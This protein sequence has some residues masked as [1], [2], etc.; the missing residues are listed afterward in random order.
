MRSRTTVALV[1]LRA[2]AGGDFFADTPFCLAAGELRALGHRADVFEVYLD[3][4]DAETSALR[5]DAVVAAIDDGGYGLVVFEHVWQP[6]L[7]R[8]ISALGAVVLLT[9]PDAAIVAPPLL[10]LRHLT[11]N[12]QP[13]LDLVAALADGSDLLQLRNLTVESERGEV[14][15]SLLEQ[16]HPQVADALRPFCPI[17]DVR[18]I[19]VEQARDGSIPPQ[20]KSLD[21]NKGCPFSAPVRE[22]PRFT[23]LALPDAGVTLAGC[24]FCF[25]GGDYQALTWRETVRIHCEQIAYY[26]RELAGHT[27]RGLDE[28]VLRD[29]HAIRYLPHLLREAI[30][31]G[32]PPLGILVPGRGDAILRYG[33]ALREAA[34]IA[35][36]TGFWFTIYLIGFE[37][38]SDDQLELYNKGVRAEDYAQALVGLRDLHHTHPETFRLYAYGSSS[39]I[40]WNPWTT[41]DDVLLTT[42]FAREHAVGALAHGIGD[43]RLRLYRNLPLWHRA[44]ADGL[45]DDDGDD[46]AVLTDAGSRHT[47]YAAATPWRYRDGRVA[48]AEA[49][50]A[51]LLRHASVEEAIGVLETAVGWA[52]RRWPSARPALGREALEASDDDREIEAIANAWVALRSLWRP[53]HSKRLEPGDLQQQTTR[54]AAARTMRVGRACNNACARC[55]GGHAQFDNDA[56]RLQRAAAR[57]AEAAAGGALVVTGREPLL[58]SSLPRLVRTAREAG[59]G[60]VEI[61]SNA[62]V[63]AIDGAAARLIGAGTSRLL[64]KRHRVADADE[65]AY[66]HAA[67]AGAQMWAGVD[68]WR[69]AGGRWRL[70][71]IVVAGAEDELTALVE[72]AAERG[73]SGVTI[74]VQAGEVWPERVALLAEALGAARLAGE[75]KGIKVEFEGF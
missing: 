2:Q 45:L 67:G 32:L 27:G 41:L 17:V 47:G 59:A 55:V 26:Q 75:R 13:L 66:A 22:N 12:R 70:L 43:T 58:L 52:A 64:A 15:H 14:R 20:R 44:A 53:Q 50:A 63:L 48:Y 56:P 60:D 16:A 25:M 37:S 57:A 51:R 1:Y 24:S 7:I 33:D 29:Q 8:R 42:R 61:V 9:E 11:N 74:A 36:G 5:L 34:E 4:E 49:L 21:T 71:A 54:K 28:V 40:L 72:I 73:V 69:A 6:S 39:F 3:R 18:K 38:F 30:A 46:D 23:D 31:R 65:D 62:R 19:G 10:R 35:A 68:A